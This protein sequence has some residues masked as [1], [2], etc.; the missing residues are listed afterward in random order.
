M[1]LLK[2]ALAL[3][4]AFVLVAAMLVIVTPKTAHAVVEALVQVANTPAQS[5]PTWRTDNDGRNVVRLVYFETMNDGTF[6]NVVPLNDA[7]TSSPY[8]VPTGKRLVIDNVSLFAL[9]NPGQKVFVYFSNGYTFTAIP[10]IDAGFPTTTLAH[11]TN[12]IPVRDYVEPAGQYSVVMERSDTVGPMIWSVH[13]VGHL[14]DC[15][16]GGGC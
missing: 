9:P 11:L 5:I 3:F 12:S 4:G 10:A 2:Q 13:A 14:V 6:S 16:N 1:K 7:T 15:T 8:T